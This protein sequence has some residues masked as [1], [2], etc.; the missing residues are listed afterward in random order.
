MD[1]DNMNYVDKTSETPWNPDRHP[2]ADTR[3]RDCA[4]LDKLH[5]AF[6]LYDKV[7]QWTPSN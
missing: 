4:I 1:F 2:Q 7:P 5:K 6:G 3:R